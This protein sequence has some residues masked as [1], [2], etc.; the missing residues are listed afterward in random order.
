MLQDSVP[1][2][3]MHFMVNG[4]QRGLQQHLIRKLYREELF[5]ALMEERQDVAAKRAQCQEVR[6]RCGG[7]GGGSRWGE[8]SEW[9]RTREVPPTL[10]AMPR[11]AEHSAAHRVGRAADAGDQ[12]REPDVCDAGCLGLRLALLKQVLCLEERHWIGL[13]ASVER[14]F[15]RLAANLHRGGGLQH[16]HQVQLQRT[17]THRGGGGQSR[18]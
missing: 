8:S 9:G 2:A 16:R 7:G 18:W 11:S 3:L 5:E 15:S 10:H 6:V 4:A 14:N 17:H 1:K 12:R 13:T